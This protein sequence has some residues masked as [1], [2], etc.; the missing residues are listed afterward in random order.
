MPSEILLRT[1]I[2]PAFLSVPASSSPVRPFMSLQICHKR[3]F[4]MSS[5]VVSSKHLFFGVSGSVK[6]CRADPAGFRIEGI[7]ER[8]TVGLGT[9]GWR[10]KQQSE[11]CDVSP[12][13]DGKSELE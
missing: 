5:F 7:R 13:N 12:E 1:R 9:I 6:S 8:S 10:F 11:T 2:A 3:T 4:R